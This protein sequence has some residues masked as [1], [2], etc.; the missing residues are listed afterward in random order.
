MTEG[1]AA[2]TRAFELDPRNKRAQ[3]NLATAYALSGR[4]DE[5]ATIRRGLAN[6]ELAT[7]RRDSEAQPTSAA[8]ARREAAQLIRLGRPEEALAAAQRALALDPASPDSIELALQ[9]SLITGRRD[10]A[11]ALLHRLV[12]ASGRRE[13]SFAD[14]AELAVLLGEPTVAAAEADLYREVTTRPS[15]A[16]R[17]K[18]YSAA[19]SG[20][21]HDARRHFREALARRST[22]CCA[23][24]WLG[25]ADHRLGHRT[26]AVH[27]ADRAEALSMCECAARRALRDAL[28]T[29]T[30]GE[31]PAET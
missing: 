11:R 4:R 19:A 29:P 2:L 7:A 10:D 23:Q 20:D 27:A 18:G 30:P 1:L 15:E 26:E 28:K 14:A 9:A 13:G 31:L 3:R 16:E 21:W 5:A 22:D 25:L 24:T 8:P 6:A 17:V 12:S